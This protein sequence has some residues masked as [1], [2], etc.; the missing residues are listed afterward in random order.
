MTFSISSYSLSYITQNPLQVAQVLSG[1]PS[2][3][4]AQTA[5]EAA[6]SSILTPPEPADAAEGSRSWTRGKQDTKSATTSA[7]WAGTDTF[8]C[9]HPVRAGFWA[10]FNIEKLLNFW[11][12]VNVWGTGASR[13]RSETKRM[14]A[15]GEDLL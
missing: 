10:E 11:R 8:T 2:S 7:L 13:L 1:L 6:L 12:C 9:F 5:A 4:G 14:D 3:S 15:A